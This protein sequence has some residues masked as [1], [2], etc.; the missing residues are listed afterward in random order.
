MAQLKI[1][2]SRF[3]RLRGLLGT[4]PNDDLV[5]LVPCSDV[6]TFGMAYPLDLAFIDAKG[7]VMKSYRN[8]EPGSRLRC[9]NA[10]AVVERASCAHKKWFVPRHFAGE[11]IYKALAKPEPVKKVS[12]QKGSS[13]E[14]LSRVSCD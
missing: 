4:L 2:R 6:H 1:Y 5:M 3:S 10:K 13:H 8:V 11:S 12:A 9:T 14:N 7:R